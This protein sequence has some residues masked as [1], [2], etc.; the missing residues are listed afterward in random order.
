MIGFRVSLT[1]QSR[2]VI[3]QHS[4]WPE[5]L[6]T[7][8]QKRLEQGLTEAENHLKINYLSG[9]AG[10]G[11]GGNVPVGLRSG[12]L[13]QSVTSKRDEPLSGFVGVT[14]GPATQYAPVILGDRDVTIRP[15]NAKH[16]WIPV[17]SNRSRRGG[18]KVTP[19]EAMGREGFFLKRSSGGGMVGLQE[20]SEGQVRLMFV[21]KKEVTIHGTD[22]L[23]LGVRD[24][25]QRIRELLTGAID[26]LEGTSN[27]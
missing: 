21:L 22:A 10:S 1:H 9:A 8:L 25:Q 4:R 26:E 11:S 19:R 27:G 6:T 12:T 23:R 17:E 3:E 7:A 5:Q 14:R 20:N 16:L 24:K 13:R 18:A 15:K 2:R